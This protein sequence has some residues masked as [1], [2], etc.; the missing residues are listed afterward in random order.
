VLIANS[1]FVHNEGENGGAV[2]YLSEYDGKIITVVES[3]FTNNVAYDGGG[4]LSCNTANTTISI[5][6]CNFMNNT[7]LGQNIG[8]GGTLTL[9]SAF[10][11]HTTITLSDNIFSNST[12]NKSGGAIS[13][14]GLNFHT[15][16]IIM[17]RNYFVNNRAGKKG[18]VLSF[19]KNPHA[20]KSNDNIILI[21]NVFENNNASEDG[22][23]FEFKNTNVKVTIKLHLY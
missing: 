23:V 7:A 11:T 17:S 19:L 10:S 15:S 1:S 13:I 9:V 5:T 22:G 12:S 2:R 20:N 21:K 18:V 16:T 6:N 3:N 8:N 14:S 4:A